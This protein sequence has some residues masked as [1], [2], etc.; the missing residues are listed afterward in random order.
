MSSMLEGPWFV[1]SKIGF[2]F[3]SAVIFLGGAT[4]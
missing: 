3:V 4:G 2:Y 1:K